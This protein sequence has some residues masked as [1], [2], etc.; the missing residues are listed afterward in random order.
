MEKMPESNITR[1]DKSKFLIPILM[2]VGEFILIFFLLYVD[3][4]RFKADGNLKR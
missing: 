1:N 3:Y 2:V 4:K